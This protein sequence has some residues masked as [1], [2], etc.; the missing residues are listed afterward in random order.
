METDIMSKRLPDTILRIFP[1]VILA[2]ALLGLCPLR[3]DAAPPKVM[4]QATKHHFMP[5]PAQSRIVTVTAK[6]K[7]ETEITVLTEA[8]A[9]KE[10][11]PKQTVAKFGEVYAFAPSFI[12]VRE[13]QPTRLTFWNL[14]PDD[15]HDFMLADRDSNVLMYVELKPL[16]RN[17]YVFTFH[18]PG[19]YSFFCAIHQPEMSGQILALPAHGK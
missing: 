16:S 3:A 11:G 9:I 6:G 8:V 19:L 10:T 14:Q 12:A 1:A 4:Q 17:S 2:A 15:D 5:G 18:K 7:A 13:N